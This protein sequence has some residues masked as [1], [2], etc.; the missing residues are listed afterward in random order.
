M[1]RALLLLA[2]AAVISA[3]R[4]LIL[5]N[6]RACATRVR[7]SH[8]FRNGHHYFFSWRHRPTSSHERDWLDARNICRKHCQD[9]VSLEDADEARAIENAVA[10]DNVRYIWTSGRLCDF[11]GC[12]DASLQPKNINGWF[13]SGSN[14]RMPA[15]DTK[16][17]QNYPNWSHTG[18]LGTKQPDSRENKEGSGEESCMGILNNFYQDGIK[19]HDVACLHEK[20]WVCEDSDE[21]LNY[22]RST[23]RRRIP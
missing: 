15:T 4:E 1:L 2:A 8:M 5:P 19:W 3:Q 6:P 7:H 14:E 16:I 13:W 21:L 23:S 12:D 17:S 18:G 22:A 10:R 20:P 11:D 9:L